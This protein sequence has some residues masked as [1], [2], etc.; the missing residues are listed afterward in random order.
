MTS[1]QTTQLWMGF[2]FVLLLILFLILAYFKADELTDG[3]RKILHFLCALCAGFAGALLA[4]DA[5]FKLDT[6][7]NATT[8][9]AISGTAG[10]ALFFV[11]WFTFDR[12]VQLPEGVRISVPNGWTFRHAVDAVVV[13]ERA[14]ANFDGFLETELSTPLQSGEIKRKTVSELLLALRLLA[15]SDGIRQYAV[16]FEDP[17]YRLRVSAS[18]SLSSSATTIKT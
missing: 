8:K 10:F 1:L 12:V 11:V 7:I 16:S 17:V 14:R 5:L 4:G 18:K 6:Q 9:V 2:G 15:P 3:Q 13:T